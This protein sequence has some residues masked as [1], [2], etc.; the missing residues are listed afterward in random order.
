MSELTWIGWIEF[1]RLVV[2]P[3]TGGISAG[4]RVHPHFML[5]PWFQMNQSTHFQR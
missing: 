2:N 4:I 1:V 3:D 5:K